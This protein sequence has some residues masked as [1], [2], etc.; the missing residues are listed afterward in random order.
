M[1]SIARICA[2]A[3]L[4]G[5]HGDALSV[6]LALLAFYVGSDSVTADEMLAILILIPVATIVGLLSSTWWSDP[7][8]AIIRRAWQPAI[9]VVLILVALGVRFTSLL[10]PV[11][12]IIFAGVTII[13][14]GRPVPEDGV[15]AIIMAG[16]L[17]TEPTVA[18]EYLM[19][20]GVYV[21]LIMATLTYSETTWRRFTLSFLTLTL[22][23]ILLGN[24]AP[25]LAALPI[26]PAIAAYWI[27]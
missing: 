3:F 7:I 2:S 25:W 21:G 10:F 22:P 14:I 9:P 11:I 8:K 27:R 4:G 6:A 23:V 18:L 17:F 15:V 16:L 13:G 24:S 19:V 5:F 12:A 1:S 26:V 20:T